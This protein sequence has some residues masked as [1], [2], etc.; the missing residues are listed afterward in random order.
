MRFANPRWSRSL[1]ARLLASHLITLLL[2][3]VLLI[4]GPLLML[5]QNQPGLAG[6]V[7]VEEA[8]DIA[9]SLRYS[10][11]GALSGVSLGSESAWLYEGFS[12]ELNFRVLDE[13]GNVL[14]SSDQDRRALSPGDVSFDPKLTFFDVERSGV[15]LHV[16]TR[17][18]DH[19]GKRLYLQV[20]ISDRMAKLTR[21]GYGS[22]YISAAALPL[23]LALL[24]F[25]AVIVITVR[26]VIKPL[27]E[28]S[29]A[30]A[31][32]APRNLG[33]RLESSRLPSELAPLINAFNSALARL[34][35]GFRVQ[36]EFLATSA[37]ELK[38]PL[39][40]IRGQ[41]ELDQELDRARLLQ[42][43]DLMSRQVQQLLDLAEVSEERNYLFEATDLQAAVHDVVDYLRPLAARGQVRFKLDLPAAE[44]DIQADRSALF[45]M[46]K[47]LIENAIQ[48][49]PADSRIKVVMTTTSHLSILDEGSG[50]A[51]SHLPRIFDRFWRG[52]ERSDHGAGLGLPICCE[53]ARAHGWS[54][55]ATSTSA[56]AE[57]RVVFGGGPAAEPTKLL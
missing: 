45:V 49:S 5:R 27:R 47:N 38:T 46:L 19:A 57:F 3:S 34:E 15:R 21:L 39:A 16:G 18:I 26:R 7:L 54:L 9:N 44:R 52:P 2:L 29:L 50:I 30:A 37:H 48:H 17:L 33:A 43:V 4:G 32:I 22:F 51:E 53:I 28:A 6:H 31:Q 10:S 11:T 14:L 42:D 12:R 20:A 23:V 35:K 13:Y 24:G 56:G 8:D 36:Q 1:T 55:E 40:L 25:V 41:L